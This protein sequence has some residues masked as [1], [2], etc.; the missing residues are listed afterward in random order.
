MPDASAKINHARS[1]SAEV[2]RSAGYCD[3]PATVH[4]SITLTEE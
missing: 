1:R 2:N 4:C 3:I